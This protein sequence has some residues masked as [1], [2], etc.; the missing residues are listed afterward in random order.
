[1][2]KITI[3]IDGYS[4]CGKSTTAKAVA[5]A[6]NYVYV[7]SGAMYRAVTYYFIEQNID[8]DKPQEISQALDKIN[9][10]FVLYADEQP[11]TMLNGANV[12]ED[13]RGMLVSGKVSKVA[14]IPAVRRAMVRQQQQMG[15]EKGL[16]MDGRDIGTVVFPNA[17]LKIFMTARPEVRAR[18]RLLELEQK[19]MKSSLEE[20]MANLEERDRIDT[21]RED[22]PLTK[23]ED[24]VVLDNSDL[25]FDQQVEKI[26]ALVQ[27]KINTWK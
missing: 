8:L 6:L 14:A 17:E 9:I 2:S 19:G 11:V 23:A 3:A 10:R 20:V 27:E 24:A 21:S 13:I 1:M 18:R 4:A 22:S 12:E 25:S 26:L 7:D 15:E 5:R 16:V